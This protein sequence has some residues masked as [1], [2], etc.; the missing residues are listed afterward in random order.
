MSVKAVA[1]ALDLPIKDAAMKLVLISLADAHNGHTGKCFPSLDRVAE[2][3][4]VSRSTVIRRLKALEDEGWIRIE[5]NHE[6]N[7]RQTANN[8]VLKLDFASAGEGVRLTP[9]TGGEGVRVT[10]TRVSAVTPPIE[11]EEELYPP[12]PLAEEFAAVMRLWP[13]LTPE[14]EKAAWDEYGKLNPTEKAQC[15]AAARRYPER[16]RQEAARR[17]RSSEEHRRYTKALPNWIKERLWQGEKPLPST[18]GLQPLSSDHPLYQRCCEI[19]G[20]QWAMDAKGAHFKDQTLAAARME[21][22]FG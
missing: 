1:W 7:G 21:A 13:K 4:C 9:S 2:Q 14:H 17:G 10:P 16:Q 18:K 5:A 6:E 19:E 3:A 12:T 20:K 8:Y 22:G 11:P 15:I